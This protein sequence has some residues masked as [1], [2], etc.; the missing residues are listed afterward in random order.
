MIFTRLLHVAMAD[1]TAK[2]SWTS[3]AQLVP[4]DGVQPRILAAD[5]L[6]PSARGKTYRLRA[7]GVINTTGTPTY[8]FTVRLNTTTASIAGAKLA[9]SVAITTIN[10]TTNEMFHLDVDFAF[11][12]EGTS[13]TASLLRALVYSPAGFA[14]PFA[15][16]MW[17][18]GAASATWTQS[19]STIVDQFISL[20]A[21]CSASS[22]SN[23]LTV[24]GVTLE[25]L[26]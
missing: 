5:L 3:E 8:L 16:S 7:S 18:G 10:N 22:A 26:N 24:K 4:S 11:R 15:Y 25:E 17:P 12:L 13:G 2:A 21:T 23:S 20:S 19:Y 1:Y 6:T 14:S 9:E